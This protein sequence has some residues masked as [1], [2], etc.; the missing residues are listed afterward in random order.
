MERRS[1]WSLDCLVQT[2]VPQQ[3]TC[4]MS[5][6]EVL[7]WREKSMIRKRS[8]DLLY[9]KTN[10]CDHNSY[11]SSL[12]L[13]SKKHKW[14]LLSQALHKVLSIGHFIWDQRINLHRWMKRFYRKQR[15]LLIKIILGQKSPINFTSIL[16]SLAKA[17][18]F[19]LEHNKKDN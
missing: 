13:S 15:K 4:K 16:R 6:D 8:M 9:K 7:F 5:P 19:Y 3:V 12:H 1:L 18:N 17:Q 11:L 10:W 2:F 14:H